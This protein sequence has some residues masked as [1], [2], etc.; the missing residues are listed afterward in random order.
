MYILVEEKDV[1]NA[2]VLS[3]F[4]ERM[5]DGRL[6][7]P[8][9]ELKMLGSVS[10]CQIVASAKELKELISSGAENSLPDGMQDD[11]NAPD[12]GEGIDAGGNGEEVPDGGQQEDT[13]NEEG[14]EGM[15]D[16]GTE[17][18]ADNGTAADGG[19]NVPET[20]GG[21]EEAPDGQAEGTDTKENINE[22]EEE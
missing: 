15:A 19:E 8:V 16:N 3:M 5:P 2:Q 10:D 20:E 6:I 18:M 12:T 4:H 13:G 21:E 9:S 1:K 7:L 22:S 11:D 17:G 14:T